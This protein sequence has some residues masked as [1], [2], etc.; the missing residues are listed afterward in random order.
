MASP[1][2][3]SS[4]TGAQS[5][6]IWFD[7]TPRAGGDEFCRRVGLDPEQRYLLYVGG[8][9]YPE[10]TTEAEYVHPRP[11]EL[12]SLH[13]IRSSP[14]SRYFSAPHPYRLQPVGP[15]TGTEVFIQHV[16]V[17]PREDQAEMPLPGEAARAD[18]YDSIFHS[19]AV[20]GINTSAMIE[21]AVVGRT[22]HTILAPGFES[23]Q[24][25]VFH[26]EYLLSAGGGLPRVAHIARRAPRAARRDDAGRRRRRGRAAAAVPRG[27]RAA[28]GLERPA[29]PVFVETLEQLGRTSVA[30]ERAPFWTALVL[31]AILLGTRIGSIDSRT[32]DRV[33]RKLAHATRAQRRRARTWAKRL[34]R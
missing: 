33:S 25:G 16:R 27:V 18:Y 34:A 15:R 31:P 5:F 3:A 21:S 7:W 24:K 4:T 9:L 22:V 6:D 10:T 23:S 13:A 19:E 8:S 26:F 20:V 29:T 14:S 32:P 2:S 17:W 12:P 30:A 11:F 28:G 1:R